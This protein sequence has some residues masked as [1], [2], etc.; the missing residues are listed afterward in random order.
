MIPTFIAPH[1]VEAQCFASYRPFNSHP[2][3]AGIVGIETLA[4][5]TPPV[6][7]P[8]VMTLP[9][10]LLGVHP[11]DADLSSVLPPGFTAQSQLGWRS[12]PRLNVSMQI[13][14]WGR[15]ASPG[16]LV[17]FNAERRIDVQGAFVA[18]QPIGYYVKR[19][20][21]TSSTP[22]AL[23]FAT[24]WHHDAFVLAQLLARAFAGRDAPVAPATTDWTYAKLDANPADVAAHNL[25]PWPRHGKAQDR[26][27]TSYVARYAWEH[28]RVWLYILDMIRTF[29]DDPIEIQPKTYM[30]DLAALC[31]FEPS[32]GHLV[33][34][35]LQ[36][37]QA[38]VQWFFERTCP[39]LPVVFDGVRYSGTAAAVPARVLQGAN[40]AEAWFLTLDEVG[41]RP[42]TAHAALQVSLPQVV[43]AMSAPE[44]LQARRERPQGA[45]TVRGRPRGAAAL[46]PRRVKDEAQKRDPGPELR[47]DQIDY[48]LNPQVRDVAE[49]MLMIVEHVHDVQRLYADNPR[50]P[51]AAHA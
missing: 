22:A 39:S 23:V 44:A 10:G 12:L 18:E 49:L 38:A 5:A 47:Q 35:V 3:S 7:A 21:A 2:G 45:Q 31:G 15:G 28:R 43:A 30:R 41:S 29:L 17:Q 25:V 19:K 32:M 51:P 4:S 36:G 11:L 14:S 1:A 24:W 16:A 34:G 37:E 48:L 40:P 6:I 13:S 9:H 42:D 8:L 33:Q 26:V 46:T 27:D 20:G 50:Q